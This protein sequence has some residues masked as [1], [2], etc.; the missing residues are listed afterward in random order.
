MIADGDF[1]ACAVPSTLRRGWWWSKPICAE[2]NAA[3]AAVRGL[4]VK[5]ELGGASNLIF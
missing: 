3:V 4:K 5:S 1:A 2:R